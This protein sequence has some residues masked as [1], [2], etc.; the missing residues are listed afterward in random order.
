MWSRFVTLSF[1]AL[2]GLACGGDRP[3]GP[4]LEGEGGPE[5]PTAAAS[6]EGHKGQSHT[7]AGLVVTR[8]TR[9][10]TETVET[11]LSALEANPNIGVVA[12]LDHSANAARV[13][14]MLPPTREIFFGNPNLGTP[15]MQSRQTVGI[16]LPQKLLIWED[17]GGEVFVA[18]NSVLYLWARHRLSGVRTELRTIAGALQNFAGVA[19]GA[20]V[21]DRTRRRDLRRIRRDRGLTFVRSEFSAEETFDRLKSAIGIAP[22]LNILFALEHDQNAAR[23]D[24]ELR[25]T[26]LVVFGNP[27]LGT[28]LMLNERSIGIDLPQK[29]LVMENRRGDVFI[30]YNDPFFIAKR[31]GVRGQE[32]QLR[33]IAGALANLARGAAGR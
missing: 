22:P 32:E 3:L 20:E 11:V 31:H 9:T 33:T 17:G 2:F 26:K 5:P 27:A 4:D 6:S 30:A 12:D 18:Y 24:L 16:D 21:D 15:L 29:F 10:F 14:L 25:P 19:T 13:G 23:V 1:L 28:P 8:S 7:P